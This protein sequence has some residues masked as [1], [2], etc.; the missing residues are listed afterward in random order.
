MQIGS[1]EEARRA[2][3]CPVTSL[4]DNSN[5]DAAEFE[6]NAKKQARR[7]LGEPTGIQ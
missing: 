4:V 7:R 6:S 1:K 5:L 2:D 3:G